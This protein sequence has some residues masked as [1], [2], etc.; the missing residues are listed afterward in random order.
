MRGMTLADTM[1]LL[2]YLCQN[3]LKV[4]WGTPQLSGVGWGENSTYGVLLGS[5]CK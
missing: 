5:C 4:P 3:A 1:C 2:F